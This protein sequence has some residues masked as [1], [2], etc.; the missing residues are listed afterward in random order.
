M[1]QDVLYR[2]VQ[3]RKPIWAWVLI[4]ALA[5]LAWAGFFEQIVRGNPV[6]TN[7]A[8]DMVI[9]ILTGV[10][11][12]LLPAFIFSLRLIIEVRP[13]ALVLRYIPLWSR[14]IELARIRSV[15]PR[16]YSPIAEYWGWGIRYMPG[17][18]WVWSVSGDRGVQLHLED[19]HP[20][21]IG[22]D[23]PEALAEA[24]ALAARLEVSARR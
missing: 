7:P 4:L 14:R 19:C 13:A 6:G 18:G 22:T 24:I 3:T 11:G 21:L 8:P 20:L 1:V 16:T 2:D 17:R 5:G 15:E 12:I 9:W 10:A 23:Q